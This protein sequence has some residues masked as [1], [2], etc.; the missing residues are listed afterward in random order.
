M[1]VHSVGDRDFRLDC[2]LGYVSSTG[3]NLTSAGEL[4]IVPRLMTRLFYNRRDS[5]HGRTL[6]IHRWGLGC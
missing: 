6:S 4:A 3:N 2:G 5:L 1:H